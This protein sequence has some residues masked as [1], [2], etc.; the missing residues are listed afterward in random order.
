MDFL[1]PLF[2]L[3]PV[4][5]LVSLIMIIIVK[6]VPKTIGWSIALHMSILI[7]AGWIWAV[8]TWGNAQAI[9]IGMA[10]TYLPFSVYCAAFIIYRSR[11]KKPTKAN[12]Y[13]HWRQIDICIGLVRLA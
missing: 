6:S 10:L 12:Q 4:M 9:L 11:P 7:P 2:L 1:A 8:I 3:F 5:I 13:T